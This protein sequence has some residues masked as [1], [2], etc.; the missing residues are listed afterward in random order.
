MNE[1]I[2]SELKEFVNRF[3]LSIGDLKTSPEYEQEMLL[4]KGASDMSIEAFNQMILMLRAKAVMGP[5]RGSKFLEVVETG[6]QKTMAGWTMENLNNNKA[7]YKHFNNS[8]EDF[9]YRGL[10]YRKTG[11]W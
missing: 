5:P 3:G 8:N 11:K 9:E 1:I 10:T 4:D 6:E 7:L 2:K